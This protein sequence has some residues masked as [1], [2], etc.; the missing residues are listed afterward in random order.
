[1]IMKDRKIGKSKRNVYVAKP[2]GYAQKDT[3]C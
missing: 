2:A 1:M 3:S